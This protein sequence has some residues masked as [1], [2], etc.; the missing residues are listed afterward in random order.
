MRRRF[1]AQSELGERSEA[2]FER[3]RGMC[4]K[5]WLLALAVRANTQVL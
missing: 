5:P 1:D 2:L 3:L 4:S